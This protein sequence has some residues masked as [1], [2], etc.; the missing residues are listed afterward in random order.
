M[1][2]ICESSS[3]LSYYG[4][5]LRLPITYLTQVRINNDKPNAEHQPVIG[6]GIH[7]NPLTFWDL[8][9]VWNFLP[10]AS[11]WASIDAACGG[12]VWAL[13]WGWSL[14]LWV[15]HFSFILFWLFHSS[16][17]FTPFTF[18]NSYWTHVSPRNILH[19]LPTICT[20]TVFFFIFFFCQKNGDKVHC[21]FSINV[22]SVSLLNIHLINIHYRSIHNCHHGNDRQKESHFFYILKL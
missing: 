5:L 22:S 3:Q 15:S 21:Q 11:S 10:F 2:M 9:T 20:H 6:G 17:P 19:N 12:E 16:F 8:W 14:P 18:S 1:N 7:L 4:I 13:E